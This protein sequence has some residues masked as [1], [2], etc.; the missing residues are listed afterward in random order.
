MRLSC[1]MALH[2]PHALH[3]SGVDPGSAWGVP[4]PA[5]LRRS[6]GPA[7]TLHPFTVPVKALMLSLPLSLVGVM[8][9]LSATGNTIKM[10]AEHRV[11]LGLVPEPI[12]DRSP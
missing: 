11:P 1:F 9:A 8:L 10:T 2:G 7:G 12:G 5:E 3:V 6:S 4:G